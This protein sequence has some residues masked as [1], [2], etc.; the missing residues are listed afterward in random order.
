V[1]ARSAEPLPG[2]RSAGSDP[3]DPGAHPAAVREA[4]FVD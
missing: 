3:A 4:F 2:A 1:V